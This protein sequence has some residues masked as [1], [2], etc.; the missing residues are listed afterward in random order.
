MSELP[1]LSRTSTLEG[2]PAISR[3]STMAEVPELKSMSCTDQE[4]AEETCALSP[5]KASA[6]KPLLS[7][8]AAS[9]EMDTLSL[10]ELTDNMPLS[11]LG[12]HLFNYHGLTSLFNMDTKKLEKF[13]LLIER[14]YPTS[15][16]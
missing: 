10:A 12:M 1:P 4:A 5:K 7:A 6:V 15:N 8:A 3:V 2:M 11:T 13:L 9:W 14:G 16:Q